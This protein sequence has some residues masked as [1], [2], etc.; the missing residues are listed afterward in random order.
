VE[1]QRSRFALGEGEPIQQVSDH[2]CKIPRRSSGMEEW[3][4]GFECFYQRQILRC[5]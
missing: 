2:E 3:G 4:K 5:G 1:A